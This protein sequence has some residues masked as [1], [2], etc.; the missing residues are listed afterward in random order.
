M[1]AA[2][3]PDHPGFFSGGY[4]PGRF[5]RTFGELAPDD[6]GAGVYLFTFSQTRKAQEWRRCAQ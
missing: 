6:W 5:L 4:E 3:F 1:P 2:E